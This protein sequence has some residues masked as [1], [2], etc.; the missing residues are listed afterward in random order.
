M[1]VEMLRHTGVGALPLDP[2]PVPD[3]RSEEAILEEETKVVQSL[4]NRSKRIQD[5]ASVV[6]G[7]LSFTGTSTSESIGASQAS[8]SG[9]RG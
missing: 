8:G 6:A 3:S 7:F 5:G 4:F 2:P 9:R 1:L